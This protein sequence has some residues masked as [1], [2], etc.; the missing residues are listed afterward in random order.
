MQTQQILDYLATQEENVLTSNASD[1]KLPANS[2]ANYMSNPRVRS[3]ACRYFFLSN[4]VTV[5]ANNSAVSN[6][7]HII[8]HVMTSKTKAKL[9]SLYI[10][11]RKA[12][13]IS[14]ILKEMGHDSTLT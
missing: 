12:V 3:R 7:T 10:M 4:N 6:I 9:A 1:T 5:P 11:A 8:K 2:E 14:I 13:Y